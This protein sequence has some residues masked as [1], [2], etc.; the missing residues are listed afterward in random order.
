[1]GAR[2]LGQAQIEAVNEAKH[3]GCLGPTAISAHARGYTRKLEQREKDHPG[4]C[5]SCAQEI[6]DYKTRMAKFVVKE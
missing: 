1:M 3:N 5:S 2:R 6:E 4:T